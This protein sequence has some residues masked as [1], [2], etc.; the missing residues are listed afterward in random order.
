MLNCFLHFD[1]VNEL[2]NVIVLA[3][4]WLLTAKLDQNDQ[5]TIVTK[6]SS[7]RYQQASDVTI[8]ATFFKHAS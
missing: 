3:V 4:G 8:L 6:K 5:D 1:S 7:W 2:N